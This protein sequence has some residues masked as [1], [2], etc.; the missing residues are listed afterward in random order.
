MSYTLFRSLEAFKTE[1]SFSTNY[2]L[3]ADMAESNVFN[4]DGTLFYTKQI[5]A[6]GE[7]H[8]VLQK[9]FNYALHFD[10]GV[11]KWR[12]NHK[13]CC[14]FI[15]MCKKALNNAVTAT[16]LP[17]Y[18]IGDIFYA[19]SESN[20]IVDAITNIPKVETVIDDG[21]KYLRTKDIATYVIL[22]RGVNQIIQKYKEKLF[23]EFSTSSQFRRWVEKN[24]LKYFNF[25]H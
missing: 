13:D 9:V 4:S 19:F 16:E 2:I 11:F 21:I 7:Y 6:D 10:T 25:N 15:K 17:P 22:K 18:V 20:C 5:I 1:I 12:P 23:S 8:E 24:S 14:G 3:I